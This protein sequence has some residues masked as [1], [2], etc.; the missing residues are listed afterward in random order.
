MASA[1]GQIT[2]VFIPLLNCGPIESGNENYYK[3]LEKLTGITKTN[4]NVKVWELI[5]SQK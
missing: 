4:Y 3:V 5:N 2:T 1:T